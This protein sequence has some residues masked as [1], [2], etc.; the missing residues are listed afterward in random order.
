MLRK[1][2]NGEEVLRAE[3]PGFGFRL[4]AMINDQVNMCFGRATYAVS[5]LVARLT[6][7]AG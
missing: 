5:T 1:E 7:Y 3:V 6:Q 4:D 2:I